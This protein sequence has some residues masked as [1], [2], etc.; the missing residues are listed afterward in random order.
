MQTRFIFGLIVFAL[1]I[2]FVAVMGINAPASEEITA[3]S[4]GTTIKDFSLPDYNG[5][6][7]TLSDF[8]DSRAI[9]LLFIAT[10][11][12]VSN[13]YNQR[14]ARLY[15]DY[16]EKGIAFI[17]IN[18]NKQESVQE[19]KEHARK[20]GLAF[21]ILKDHENHIADYFG[22]TVTPEVFVLNPE[23]KILYHGRID[24]S[25]RVEKVTKND[26]RQVLDD[27]LAGKPVSVQETRAF[28]CTIKR[29]G[30]D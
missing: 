25:R 28:G 10:Q 9:V 4:P 29:V 8:K 18:S 26:L 6:I 1:I 19:I 12:P 3:L 20:N 30:K 2:S 13:A 17:G 14:M 5:Q 24:D 7:H 21:L 15:E 23:F 22:A 16:R 11:C 27:I